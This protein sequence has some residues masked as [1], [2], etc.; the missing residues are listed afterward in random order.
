MIGLESSFGL[1]HKT[2]KK[3]KI[4]IK[5]IIDLFTVN[6]S[7]II[8]IIPNSIQEGELAEINIIDS[9]KKWVFNSEDIISKSKNS[10]LIGMNLHGKVI[11][12]FN[13]GYFS[14]F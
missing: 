4:N 5:S 14:S 13:K 1:V 8:N 6:P 12:T 2:L 7:K 3:E 11:G 9:T 10:P